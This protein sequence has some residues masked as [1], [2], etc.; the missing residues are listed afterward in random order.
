MV[1]ESCHAPGRTSRRSGSGRVVRVGR[2]TEDRYRPGHPD[3]LI[4]DLLVQGAVSRC[5][6]GM[7]DRQGCGEGSAVV[8]QTIQRPTAK[9]LPSG[10]WRDVQADAATSR[11]VHAVQSSGLMVAH[12]IQVSDVLRLRGD[13]VRLASSRASAPDSDLKLWL[14][15]RVGWYCAVVRDVTLGG[16]NP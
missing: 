13:H 11:C 4:D 16:E 9:P 1:S 7:R 3:R 14:M 10:P 12:S 5:G 15:R 8:N 2:R 6:R